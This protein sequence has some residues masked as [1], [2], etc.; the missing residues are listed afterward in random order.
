MSA[1]TRRIQQQREVEPHCEER[2]PESESAG[3][4]DQLLLRVPE[5]AA[6]GKL[7]TFI[8]ALPAVW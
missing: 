8:R 6:G 2:R 5:A 1:D 3:R 4:W 7:D